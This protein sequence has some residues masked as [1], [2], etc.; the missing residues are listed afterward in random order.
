MIEMS[1]SANIT[2]SV[3]LL[4]AVNVVISIWVTHGRG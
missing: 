4:L 3:I 2:L 1:E